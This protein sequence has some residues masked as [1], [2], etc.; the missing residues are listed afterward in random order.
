MI[1]CKQHSIFATVLVCATHFSCC[2]VQWTFI[3]PWCLSPHL[4]CCQER[5]SLLLCLARRLPNMPSC[6]SKSIDGSFA[7]I[8]RCTSSNLLYDMELLGC[9]KWRQLT[10]N[11]F[12]CYWFSINPCLDFPRMLV[13]LPQE[14]KGIVQWKEL[15][16]PSLHV[17][18]SNVLVVYDSRCHCQLYSCEVVKYRIGIFNYD[19]FVFIAQLKISSISNTNWA[20]FFH[21]CGLIELW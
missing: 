12:L 21:V 17:Y 8:S 1:S 13:L 6:S 5:M 20:L 4:P 16:L 15:M 11:L 3:L 19:A 7:I 14:K 9:K 2:S 10:F 18:W